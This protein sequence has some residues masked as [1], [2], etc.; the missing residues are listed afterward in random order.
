MSLRLATQITA[1]ATAVLALFA[2]ISAVFAYLAFRKQSAEVAILRKQV[3]DAENER[4]RAQASQIRLVGSPGMGDVDI[5]IRNDSTRP[6]S[7][8]ELSGASIKEPLPPVLAPGE[9][10]QT[11][12]DIPGNADD[13]PVLMLSFRD[14]EGLRWRATSRGELTGPL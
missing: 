10:F 1:V 5:R 2:I 6:I 8:L 13:P 3:A 4:R 7:D 11:F 12:A 14:A 9:E